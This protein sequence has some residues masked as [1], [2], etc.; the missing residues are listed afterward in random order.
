MT[1][2]EIKE[3]YSMRDVLSRYGMTPN[4]A[5]MIHCP[6]HRGDRTPSMKVY[7]QDYHCFAC[8]AHGDIFRFIQD[9]DGVSFRDAF[10]SLGGTYKHDHKVNFALYHAEK[11][12]E[13][14]R[15]EKA[16]QAEKE[17]LNG[18]LISVYRE[19]IDKLPPFS[20]GWCG[21]VNALVLE[22]AKLEER[23]YGDSNT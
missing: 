2:E 18:L 11:R 6:F 4:R 21:C 17:G 19:W 7:K 9:M 20:D 10:E 5:G 16:R 3:Q 13:M 14:K 12:R 1:K 23:I 8:G 15:R 22:I